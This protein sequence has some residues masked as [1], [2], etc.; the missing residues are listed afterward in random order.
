MATVWGDVQGGQGLIGI[1]SV[2]ISCCAPG[3]QGETLVVT[4]GYDD[5]SP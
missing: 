2:A 4:E 1:V 3:K 5:F